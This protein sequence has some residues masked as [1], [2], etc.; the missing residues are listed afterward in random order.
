M[1][2]ADPFDLFWAHVERTPH[3]PA[4]EQQA[5]TVTYGELGRC[6]QRLAGAIRPEPTDRP[7][8]VM[9]HLPKCPEAY[10]AM[11]ATLMAGG[12]YAPQNL[13]A[14]PHRLRSVRQRLEPDVIVT[15]KTLV[16]PHEGLDDVGNA[17]VILIEDLPDRGL[18]EPYPPGEL[19]Y[20]MFTSGSTGVPKG[21]MIRR[22]ALAAYTEWAVSALAIQPEDRCPQ[23]PN[24]GFDLSVI[25][26]YATLCG[27]A[28][29][30]PLTGMRDRLAPALAI[31][32]LGLTVWVSVPSVIDLMRRARHIRPAHLASLRQMFFCGEALL[33][34]HLECLF[35]ARPDIAIINAYGPTEATVSCTENQ[36][37]A[38]NHAQACD[39][40][41]AIG[42]AIPGMRIALMSEGRPAEAG[43]IVIFGPQLAAGYWRDPIQTQAVFRGEGAERGYYTGD[44]AERRGEQ[45]FYRHRID[46][47]VKVRGH[48][49]ELGEV[50]AA[51]REIG[52]LAACT[53][54]IDGA[55]TSFVESPGK[56]DPHALQRAVAERL[57]RYAVPSAIHPVV[58]LPRGLNDK[59]ETRALIERL[60]HGQLE[61]S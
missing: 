13:D 25:D 52:V 46:R 45:L 57:P 10:A 17:T 44:W 39:A 61:R 33:P 19:A 26:I 53:V 47:Q 23:H 15:S 42:E 7:P 31:G 5:R 14:P 2:S 12:C 35:D 38:T 1:R 34:A 36:L 9:I 43:E 56:I 32:E 24:L 22:S 37:D 54:L 8:V 29:L 51:L 3:R 30:L 4:I 18:A 49:L 60:R 50:D 11:F 55:V 27:G 6:V 16:G 21:V 59:I 58:A 41:V 48:R 40:T 20:V 28:T